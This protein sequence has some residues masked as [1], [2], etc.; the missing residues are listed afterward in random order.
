M[1]TNLC[2]LSWNKKIYTLYNSE[3]ISMKNYIQNKVNDVKKKG[4]RMPKQRSREWLIL[5]NG[6]INNKGEKIIGSIGG[7]EVA[8]LLGINPWN[9]EAKLVKEKLSNYNSFRGNI[10]TRWG[11]VMESIS[12]RICE[13]LFNTVIEEI[14]MLYGDINGQTYSPDGLAIV[15]LKCKDSGNI[16]LSNGK[17][18]YRQYKTEFFCVLFEFK[19]PY[20]SVPNGKIQKY[21]VPQIQSGL[22]VIQSADFAL[23]VNSLHRICALNDLR[24]SNKY[25]NIF[26]YKDLTKINKYIPLSKPIAMGIIIIYQTLQDKN[27]FIKLTDEY[28]SDSDSDSD[29]DFSGP[30]SRFTVMDFMNEKSF[31]KTQKPV[32]ATINVMDFIDSDSDN[33]S[34]SEFKDLND[35]SDIEKEYD[36]TYLKIDKIIKIP[37][38]FSKKKLYA[39]NK[40]TSNAISKILEGYDC[41]NKS[42]IFT[43]AICRKNE[44]DLG[45]S[46][47][48]TVSRVFELIIED[49]TLKVMHLEPYIVK[50]FLWRIDFL[51]NQD[52]EIPEKI[53]ID[54]MEDNIYKTF[55]KQI[56]NA[57]HKLKYDKNQIPTTNEIVAFLPWKM[58]ECDIILE[59][60]DPVMIKNIK[61]KISKTIKIIN[62]IK[63]AKKSDKN[64][65]YNKYYPQ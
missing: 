15:Q 36:Y 27:E 3:H 48:E 19:N 22:S 2:K 16:I 31:K 32:V 4:D 5:K 42:D 13:L 10:A 34:D 8:I 29:E 11:I 64:H 59:D 54:K 56:I 44:I 26:H 20:S 47:F 25:N 55:C 23:F 7:S 50:E 49:K 24:I 30:D 12:T 41:N 39:Q 28:D 14:N 37:T 21:Y 57:R 45:R 52:I 18:I 61:K 60:R 63:T 1:K 62:E 46:N 6:G 43:K 40:K 35:Q 33:D 17:I 53:Y 38:N 51:Y 58:F 9:T 65:I